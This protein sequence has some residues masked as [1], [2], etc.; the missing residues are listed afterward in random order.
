ME[1]IFVGTNDVVKAAV[2]RG[3][4]VENERA[5]LASFLSAYDREIDGTVDGGF[6]RGQ[7]GKDMYQTIA[8]TFM[9]D[10]ARAQKANR[11]IYALLQERPQAKA[12]A[13]EKLSWFEIG[14]AVLL[15][16]LTLFTGCDREHHTCVEYTNK[17]SCPDQ[18]HCYY[19]ENGYEQCDC[20]DG[21]YLE[22]DKYGGHCYEYENDPSYDHWDTAASECPQ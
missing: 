22:W 5:E 13:Q 19:D 2:A 3:V 14:L 8:H 1:R 7:V 11:L 20:P 9:K 15:F 12:P 18:E 10:E 4:I 16:P 21:F 6:R 17:Q